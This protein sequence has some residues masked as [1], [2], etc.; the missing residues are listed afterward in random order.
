MNDQT[1]TIE[2]KPVIYAYHHGYRVVAKA[3]NVS[4][5]IADKLVLSNH[6]LYFT[7]RRQDEEIQPLKF[8]FF[9]LEIAANEQKEKC[10]VLARLEPRLDV[11]SHSGLVSATQFYVID[12]PN[13]KIFEDELHANAA[14][15]MAKIPFLNFNLDKLGRNEVATLSPT[16]LNLDAGAI[17]R[18]LQELP[19]SPILP[20]LRALFTAEVIE[21]MEKRQ[22]IF[23][24][25]K[26]FT[27]P[28]A[29]F[30]LYCRAFFN[31]QLEHYR[32]SCA[33]STA[34]LTTAISDY[35]FVFLHAAADDEITSRRSGV[36]VIS[37]DN[38]ESGRNA[39]WYLEEEKLPEYHR[40]L[41]QRIVKPGYAAIQN[42]KPYCDFLLN[43]KE[44]GVIKDF[45][46]QVAG[47]LN[48][49]EA[50][51]RVVIG[52]DLLN[53]LAFYKISA[54]T[55]D[56]LR[57]NGGSEEL[58]QKLESLKEQTWQGKENF[59]RIIENTI[60]QEQTQK[61]RDVI[62]TGSIELEWRDTN[63]Q[64]S[65][66]EA[67]RDLFAVFYKILSD[68]TLQTECSADV[69]EPF[70]QLV[71][72]WFEFLI[73]NCTTW[74]GF[75]T[76]IEDAV[77][78]FAH[79]TR[80]IKE[81]ILRRML[82]EKTGLGCVPDEKEID[83]PG[84]IF[85]VW[86]NL[87]EGCTKENPVS[88]DGNLIYEKIWHQQIR[89]IIGRI[90]LDKYAESTFSK[91]LRILCHQL[92]DLYI[93]KERTKTLFYEMW[94]AVEARQLEETASLILLEFYDQNEFISNDYKSIFENNASRLEAFIDRIIRILM[95]PYDKSTEADYRHHEK[96]VF[97][98]VLRLSI[99]AAQP[100]RFESSSLCEEIHTLVRDNFIFTG[101]Y[102]ALRPEQHFRFWQNVEDAVTTG[103]ETS[104]KH[105]AFAN[106]MP[107]Q[108]ELLN[109]LNLIEERDYRRL[110][111][112]GFFFVLETPE[113]TGRFEK[114][115]PKAQKAFYDNLCGFIDAAENVPRLKQSI[116]PAV[117]SYL[118]QTPKGCEPDADKC[119][120][121]M[122]H[123]VEHNTSGRGGFAM[124]FPEL[125]KGIETIPCN[126][127]STQLSF[128]NSGGK[129]YIRRL[130][131]ES[132][133]L[134]LA[135]AT[136]DRPERIATLL[137]SLVKMI[138]AAEVE[139]R[140]KELINK[141][142]KSSLLDLF[143]KKR[144]W[145]AEFNRLPKK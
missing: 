12:G 119:F 16:R 105:P 104:R 120:E 94:R 84:L 32:K 20:E 126:L 23:V 90:N 113:F 138:G 22:K 72:D 67:L 136:Q 102:P 25:S 124:A 70:A 128:V 69:L 26:K 64:R 52:N 98:F 145:E 115:E 129:I 111:V 75:S 106:E 88:F 61:W 13:C 29:I 96:L 77:K 28:I 10:Y 65:R 36:K 66:T 137:N 1:I 19:A 78:D 112:N 142:Y 47:L 97:K 103:I 100:L 63:N 42:L 35:D 130:D 135:A 62:L 117:W 30:N 39:L 59:L 74:A 43:R 44:S 4:Q 91:S 127:K 134:Q 76:I 108:A 122:I 93:E 3:H 132:Y 11:V 33:F 125:C 92:N 81:K 5:Q 139:W 73:K 110:R 116:L 49:V 56:R 99:L 143:G 55:L 118:Q 46:F 45:N 82:D 51:D 18:Q 133:L 114:L 48:F 79:G 101:K 95:E 53:V 34:E 37:L 87:L 123:F 58:L 89:E 71:I 9:P 57:S 109:N 60:G 21:A 41:S 121:K 68:S 107:I 27:D 80:H 6:H 85:S 144:V 24:Y 7:N 31:A 141:Y 83:A 15:L 131:D 50:L 17:D 2:L 54:K 140:I 8:R 14:F 38:A 86:S 40:M